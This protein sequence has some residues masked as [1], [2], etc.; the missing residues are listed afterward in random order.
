MPAEPA[1]QQT[2]QPPLAALRRRMEESV[3]GQ[4]E[5]IEHMLIAL[6]AGGHLLVEGVP[7]LAKTRRSRFWAAASTPASTAC[8][9]RPTCC[10]RT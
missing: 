2:P 10:P 9:S 7:G 1:P 8:S 5:F 6:L 4:E 3:L